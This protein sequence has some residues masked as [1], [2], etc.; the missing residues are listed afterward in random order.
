MEAAEAEAAKKVAEVNY[1]QSVL[2]EEKLKVERLTTEMNE[3]KGRVRA[4]T[5]RDK[6]K[7]DFLDMTVENLQTSLVAKE[8]ENKL[9]V[10]KEKANVEAMRR[11][12]RDYIKKH[13]QTT[14]DKEFA[15]LKLEKEVETLKKVGR[16]ARMVLVSSFV[17]SLFRCFPWDL[18]PSFS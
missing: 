10:E 14:M 11:Q 2:D 7:I 12:M 4:S 13:T 5:E 6:A 15:V 9:E 8:M 16:N 1:T 3:M 18:P 17:F